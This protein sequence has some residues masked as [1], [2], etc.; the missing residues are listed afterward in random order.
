ML[1][2]FYLILQTNFLN[3]MIL[4]IDNSTTLKQLKLS[5][6]TDIFNLIN[7]ER[8]Y[9]GKWLPF[10]AL[11]KEITDTEQFIKSI[12]EAP[13]EKREYVF[14]IRRDNKFI[15]LIGFKDTDRSN[16]KT[17][18]GYWLSETYQK[19][20]IITNAVKELCNFAFNTLNI[21]RVVIKCAKENI[22]SINV[23]NRLGFVYEGTERDGEILTGGIYT[24]LKI[25]SMLKKEFKY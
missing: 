11:T 14:T 7:S 4:N 24:D 15:G 20:G 2:T 8:D 1:I 19:Q 9:L 25:F 17:E 5:D 6:S 16:A 3:E 12:I 21:N 22:P 13:D 23:A 10:V 18:I